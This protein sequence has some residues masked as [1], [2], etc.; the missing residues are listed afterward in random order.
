MQFQPNRE[1][2]PA[3]D[4]DAD[5][6]T[7]IL[8]QR[9]L[10]QSLQILDGT[11]KIVESQPI[12]PGQL[13]ENTVAHEI[14]GVPDLKGNR[15]LLILPLFQNADQR[16]GLT[17]HRWQPVRPGQKSIDPGRGIGQNMARKIKFKINR[18]RVRRFGEIAYHA[19]VD[20]FQLGVQAHRRIQQFPEVS[21]DGNPL[22]GAG[23]AM[24]RNIEDEAGKFL[25]VLTPAKIIDVAANH[26]QGTI[27]SPN[28]RQNVIEPVRNQRLL[29]IRRHGDILEDQALQFPFGGQVAG[30][31]HQHVGF[32]IADD[33]SGPLDLHDA[34]VLPSNPEEAA[35][36]LTTGQ[37]R[38]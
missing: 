10:G 1:R 7:I 37:H 17:N 21:A 13:V 11:L 28:R 38:P 4:V 6:G 23:D 26:M 20:P 30:G 2:R 35:G 18:R 15:H 34:P 19:P 14:E 32:A 12:P 22:Q 29:H 31:K 16:P 24:P 25:V 9:R 36:Q 33:R 27:D 5:S 8:A 3:V